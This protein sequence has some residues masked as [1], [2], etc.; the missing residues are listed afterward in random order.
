MNTPDY[1]PKWAICAECDGQGKFADVQGQW[2]LCRTCGGYGSPA[3]R[4]Y[5]EKHPDQIK[6][7]SLQGNT[8]AVDFDTHKARRNLATQIK[9]VEPVEWSAI[10]ASPWGDILYSTEADRE[11]N[12]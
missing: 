4:I 6:P 5:G 11:S 12:R 10:A 3:A 2:W 9:P 7:A 1:D 8:N